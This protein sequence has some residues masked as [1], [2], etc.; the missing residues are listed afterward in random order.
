M[1]GH[2][3]MSQKKKKSP[4]FLLCAGHSAI[5]CCSQLGFF[6]FLAAEYFSRIGHKVGLYWLLLWRLHKV[7]LLSLLRFS[8]VK[9]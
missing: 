7:A 6:S 1:K 8:Y 3:V 2:E 9:I 5:S 4:S